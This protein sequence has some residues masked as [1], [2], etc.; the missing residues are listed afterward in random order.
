MKY[1]DAVTSPLHWSLTMRALNKNRADVANIRGNSS[2]ANNRE[3]RDAFT[4][5]GHCQHQLNAPSSL[6]V[7]DEI[8]DI[9]A[10]A[11]ASYRPLTTKLFLRRLC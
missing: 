3:Q 4:K 8:S 10:V 7:G 11:F 9:S 2:L 6:S 5:R 1:P